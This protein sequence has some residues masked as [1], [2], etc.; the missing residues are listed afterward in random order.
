VICGAGFH[1]VE[2]IAT[3]VIA[4]LGYNVAGVG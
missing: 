3:G 2:P 4:L 1:W